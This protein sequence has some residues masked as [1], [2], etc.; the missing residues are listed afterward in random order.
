ML[1]EIT[2]SHYI[3]YKSR[4]RYEYKLGSITHHFIA[5]HKSGSDHNVFFG[6]D[7]NRNKTTVAVVLAH[8]ESAEALRDAVLAALPH[9]PEQ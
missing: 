7:G 6:L 3:V 5:S 8:R 1:A 9:K 2:A 4:E